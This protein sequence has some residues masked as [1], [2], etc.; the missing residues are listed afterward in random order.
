MLEPSLRDLDIPDRLL[1]EA[2]LDQSADVVGVIS[3][4]LG[5]LRDRLRMLAEHRARAS[6]LP[7]RFAI[8]GID[9]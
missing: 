6:K 5:E 8:A 2:Q 9:A 7:M 1:G 3:E 4:H